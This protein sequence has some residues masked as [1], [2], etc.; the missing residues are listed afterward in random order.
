MNKLTIIGNLTADPILRT[1][2]SGVSVCSFTVAVN[3]RYDRSKTTFIGVSAWRKTGEMCAQYLAK[4][5]KVAVTGPVSCRA[6]NANGEARAALEMTADDV[7]FLS[8][9][10]DETPAREPANGGFTE[11]ID[12]D[13]LPF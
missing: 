7:E 2:P 10:G 5:R 12:E 8:P 9:K 4:G 1:T 13:M 6:Y 3:D 11:V